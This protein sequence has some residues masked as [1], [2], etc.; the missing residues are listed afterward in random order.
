[1]VWSNNEIDGYK[2]VVS[3]SV[4]KGGIIAMDPRDLQVCVW[5]NTEIVVDPYTLAAD[6]AIRLIV[7]LNVDVKLKGDR[8]AA[9]IFE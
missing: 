6:N 1:M 9:A 2:A 8:I 5:R 3:N 7:N 4:T